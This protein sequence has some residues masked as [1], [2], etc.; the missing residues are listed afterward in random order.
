MSKFTMWLY[1]RVQ[2]LSPDDHRHDADQILTH[3]SGLPVLPSR[4]C[5]WFC[6]RVYIYDWLSSLFFEFLRMFDK[7][8]RA[9]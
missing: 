5:T 8:P 6:H 4:V 9:E 2:R 3:R 1:F 7:N